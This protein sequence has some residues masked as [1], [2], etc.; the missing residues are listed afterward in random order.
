MRKFGL[1]ACPPEVHTLTKTTLLCL[2]LA[3]L[4]CAR[5]EL[6]LPAVFSD[7]MVFQRD[8]PLRVWGRGDPG[9]TVTVG[10]A[11]RKQSGV[12]DDKGRWSVRLEPPKLM[13]Q[14]EVLTV[15]SSEGKQRLEIRNVLVGDVWFCSGQSNMEI[16]VSQSKNAQE[17]ITSARHPEIRLLK[18]QRDVTLAAGEE[19]PIALSWSPCTPESVGDFSAVAYYFGREIQRETGVPIGLIQ[20]TWGGTPIEPWIP[21]AVMKSDSEC[22]AVLK[23][24]DEMRAKVADYDTNFGNYVEQRK[25]ELLELNRVLW[26]WMLRQKEAKEKGVTFTEPA[27]QPRQPPLPGHQNTP[28]GLFNA[29]VSPLTPFS[30]RGVIWYQ[31]E[32]NANLVESARL[33][34]KQLPLLIKSWREAW[35]RPE[36]PF[37]FVQ[38]AN[39]SAVQ[40]EPRETGGWPLLRDMQL[41]TWRTIPH[42]GMAVA[43]DLGEADNVHPQNKQEVGRRLALHAL[44]NEYG[45]TARVSGPILRS[46]K[47]DGDKIKLDFEYAN[48]GLAARVGSPKGFALGDASGKWYW[49][50]AEISDNAI[51]LRSEKV[52]LPSAVAYGWASNPIGNIYDQSSGLP[53]VPFSEKIP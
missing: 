13:A 38:I 26:Q 52:P 51:S 6:K 5:A 1:I 34:G 2:S 36:L 46:A 43:I 15:V 17:E 33:Y 18:V 39:Y 4:P 44:N 9:A 25:T 11:N 31:G 8:E 32:S 20:S 3:L 23:P 29:M 7:N 28:G 10:F 16:P 30:I 37:Y 24:W 49:A 35:N 40:T 21:I 41:Q 42:T 50:E 53:L 12:V 45:K 27:P 19:V 22:A 48:G 47:R 14:P